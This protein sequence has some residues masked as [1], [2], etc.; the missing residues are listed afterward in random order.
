[1]LTVSNRTLNFLAAAVWY[2]GGM[3]LLIKSSSLLAEAHELRPQQAWTWI[4]IVAGLTIGG[5]KSKY[6]FVKSCRK[7]LFRIAALNNPQIWQFFRPGFFLALAA[8][9]TLGA[10]LSNM[11]H[12]NYPFLCAVA[13]LDL[14]IATALLGS[15]YIFWQERVF[16]A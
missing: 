8:M 5:L 1:M 15:S 7:N 10:T 2:I 9:I 14:T 6:L 16:S 12:H 3:V 13:A 11:A 4:S